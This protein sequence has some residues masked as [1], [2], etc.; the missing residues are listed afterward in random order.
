MNTIREYIEQMF[1][2]VPVTEE[3]AQLKADI[4]ANLEDKYTAL[5]ESGASEHEAIGTVIAEFGDIDE[6]LEEFGINRV[7]EQV[8]KQ[9]E[10][11][12]ESDLRQYIQAKGKM[13]W[14][15][16]LGVLACLTGIAGLL[17]FL[18]FQSVLPGALYIGL[19]FLVG[20]SVI[21]IGLFIIEGMKAGE[22]ERFSSP[23]IILPGDK[24]QFVSEQKD[25]KRSFIFSIVAGVSLCIMSITPI[26]VGALTS[27]LPVLVGVA[28]SLL[29][30][31]VGIIF[32]TYS[33]NIWSAYESIKQNGKFVEVIEE[34]T[35][36]HKRNKKVDYM[37][38]EIYWPIIVVIYFVF[39]FTQGTWAWSWII[40]VLA[41]ALES[42]IKS[43]AG[44]W[45]KN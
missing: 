44:N 12:S 31:G 27:V 15:I 10:T 24:E 16:G 25:Y 11:M 37:I 22:L 42:T 17:L 5:K 1:R 8:T 20:F 29:L 4:L 30:I 35:V 45:D 34:E 9:Y 2:G 28:F 38:D 33:G 3:T 32:F 40:F 6:L 14:N 41:G 23:Y 26:L 7:D 13:G 43:L 19:L 39:S 36:K 21:G 18:A